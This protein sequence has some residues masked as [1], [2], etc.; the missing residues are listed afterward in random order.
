MLWVP[1]K[2]FEPFFALNENFLEEIRLKFISRK[3]KTSKSGR[4]DIGITCKSYLIV[5]IKLFFIILLK[6]TNLQDRSVNCLLN[7]TNNDHT[8]RDATRNFLGQRRFL[9]IRTLQ[10]TFHLPCIKKPAG[11]LKFFLPGTLK[12]HFKWEHR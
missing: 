9:W 11:I 4:S 10:Y 8:L 3:R 6:F 2:F 5:I 1:N 12:Q 7:V